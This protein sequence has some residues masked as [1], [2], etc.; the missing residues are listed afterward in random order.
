MAVV[1]SLANVITSH[2]AEQRNS[3]AWP[4]WGEY[5]W[6]NYYIADNFQDE[7]SFLKQWIAE[8]IDWMDAQLGF[9]P[10]APELG[11]VNGDGNINIADVTALIRYVLSGDDTGIW[12]DA[13]DCDQNGSTTVSDVTALINMVLSGA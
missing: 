10:N 12:L 7:V 6:P 3:Q 1:D 2:G 4:R 13:A 5:V 8:R 11:D 9:D